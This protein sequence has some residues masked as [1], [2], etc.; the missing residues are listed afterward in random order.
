MVPF[1][2]RKITAFRAN[3]QISVPEAAALFLLPASKKTHISCCGVCF[4]QIFCVILHPVS[5]FPDR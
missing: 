5:A 1:S 2:E 4:F 3:T